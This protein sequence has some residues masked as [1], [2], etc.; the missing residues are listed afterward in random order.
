[1][2]VREGRP[3]VVF[4]FLEAGIDVNENMRPERR[5]GFSRGRPTTALLLAI[6]N[7]HFELA[8]ALLKAG[9][10]PNDHPSGFPALPAITWVRKPIRGD[11]DPPPYGSGT[12][13]SSDIV[14][15]L[16]ATG[17]DLNARLEKGSSGRGKFTT[18]GSTPFLMASRNCDI[19]LM[20]LLYD[21]GSD[22]RI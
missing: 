2:A 16:V 22:P 5:N 7:G 19:P 3:A 13:S 8:S 17:A 6:E 1:F 15:Q 14:R 20:R 12:L 11:G 10:D 9:A 21:L 18:T 4:R